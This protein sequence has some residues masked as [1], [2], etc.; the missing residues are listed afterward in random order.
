MAS[1]KAYTVTKKG[2]KDRMI[3]LDA[4][5]VKKLKAD[6]FKATVVTFDKNSK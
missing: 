3:R 2:H 6:G 5:G 4:D 1:V